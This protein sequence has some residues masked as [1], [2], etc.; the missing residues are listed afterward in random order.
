[1]SRSGMPTRICKTRPSAPQHGPPA[2]QTASP[3]SVTCPTNRSSRSA[4]GVRLAT[5]ISERLQRSH[6]HAFRNAILRLRG[7]LRGT[8][9]SAHREVHWTSYLRS[10][11]ESTSKVLDSLHRSTQTPSTTLV[12]TPA[13]KQTLRRPASAPH[14]QAAASTSAVHRC[15]CTAGDQH[16][17]SRARHRPN[18]VVHY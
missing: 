15:G 13:A 12:P 16:A 4:A 1:M 14:R 2:V 8:A 17:Q 5:S 11:A 10:E 3:V 9:H 7:H 6:V 18:R